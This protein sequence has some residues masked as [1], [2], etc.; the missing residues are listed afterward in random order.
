MTAQAKELLIY[1]GKE[2]GM[3]AE[4]LSNYFY[5][6]N[7]SPDF[8]C[9]SSACWRGYVGTWY[10]DDNKL[11]LSSIDGRLKDGST[12]T[13]QS[14]FPDQCGSV[15][16]EWFSGKI[17]LVDGELLHYVH[18]GYSSIYE[19]DILL[20]IKEGIIVDKNIKQNSALDKPS[21]EPM[22]KWLLEQFLEF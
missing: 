8:Q 11:Y 1:D 5:K 7:K 12:V 16:A 14:I 18:M 19:R 2:Y 22:P 17:R 9:E 6:I 10:I 15:F 21:E 20:E 3:C 13:I 4:P